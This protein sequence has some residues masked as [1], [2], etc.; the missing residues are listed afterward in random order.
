MS[1]TLAGLNMDTPDTTE[2]SRND[3]EK[4]SKEEWNEAD[5]KVAKALKENLKITSRSP[6][7]TS[8]ELTRKVLTWKMSPRTRKRLLKTSQAT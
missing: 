3:Q 7:P 4:C 6:P 2:G 5:L 1:N 8:T